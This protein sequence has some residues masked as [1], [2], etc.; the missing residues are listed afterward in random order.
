MVLTDYV[1]ALAGCRWSLS[2]WKIMS[3]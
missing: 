2:Y 3:A 1:C